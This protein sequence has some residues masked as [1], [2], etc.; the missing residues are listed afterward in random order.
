MPANNASAIAT[1]S[2]FIVELLHV[3]AHAS[4]EGNKGCAPR[5]V[6]LRA[7]ARADRS[8]SRRNS[9][10]QHLRYGLLTPT[11][12]VRPAR[13]ARVASTSDPNN[14]CRLALGL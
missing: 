4:E 10:R 13:S 8:P 1:T 11:R 6:A 14:T 3:L 2:F 5:P 9:P 12:T 7:Y